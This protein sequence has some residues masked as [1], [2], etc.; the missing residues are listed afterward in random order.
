MAQTSDEYHTAHTFTGITGACPGFSLQAAEGPAGFA[1]ALA[2][3]LDEDMTNQVRF[4]YSDSPSE[5]FLRGLPRAV[6][7]AEDFLH[8]VLRMEH[9]MRE[10]R[11]E[12]TRE[13]LELQKKR[14]SKPAP[15]ASSGAPLPT[16]R[17]VSRWSSSPGGPI[18]LVSSTE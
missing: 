9:C 13:V 14:G 5:D 15:A 18:R 12:C 10:R 4:L 3:L 2:D 6:G 1:A 11:T 16:T 7:C 17:H 8:L